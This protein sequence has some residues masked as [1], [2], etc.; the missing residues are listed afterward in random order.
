MQQPYC[1]IIENNQR[2]EVHTAGKDHM[3]ATNFILFRRVRKI[4]NTDCMFRHSVRPSVRIQQLGS[5]W[6]DFHEI[7]YLSIYRKYVE[8]IQVSLKSNK[9]NGYFIGTPVYIYDNISLNSS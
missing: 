9:N 5:H 2:Q 8:N 4:A 3:M 1:H 7:W 6:T